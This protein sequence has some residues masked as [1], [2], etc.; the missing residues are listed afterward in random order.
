MPQRLAAR[1]KGR[2]LVCCA[3]GERRVVIFRLLG[4]VEDFH[5]AALVTLHELPNL[6]PSRVNCKRVNDTQ[7]AVRRGG[8]VR[9]TPL[10]LSGRSACVTRACAVRMGL[11]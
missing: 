8:L 10:M 1:H 5:Y 9:S 6:V 2:R 11:A 4:R 3:L 7:C